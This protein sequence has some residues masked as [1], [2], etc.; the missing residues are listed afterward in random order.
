MNK[1]MIEDTDSINDLAKANFLSTTTFDNVDQIKEEAKSIED[2]AKRTQEGL[3]QYDEFL[4]AYDV[5]V[6][7]GNQESADKRAGD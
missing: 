6:A 2:Q 5:A 1:N 3:R 7:Q 4:N